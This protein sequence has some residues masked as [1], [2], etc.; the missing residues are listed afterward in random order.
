MRKLLKATPYNGIIW[1]VMIT[2]TLII[3]TG[4]NYF[5]DSPDYQDNQYAIQFSQEYPE[6]TTINLTETISSTPLPQNSGRIN[7][8]ILIVTLAVIVVIVGI[9]LNRELVNK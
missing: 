7:L 3:T 9:W 5:Y 8:M 1:I 4:Q 6:P 2:L